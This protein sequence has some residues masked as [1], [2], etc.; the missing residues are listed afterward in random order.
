MILLKIFL[1]LVIKI[2]KKILLFIQ[3]D[4][5]NTSEN[6]WKIFVNHKKNELIEDFL[7]FKDFI[8]LETRKNGLPC[9]IQVNKKIKKK[10]I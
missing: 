5:N 8:I 7:C 10:H 3:T 2:I 6:N 9:L 4:L 1:F